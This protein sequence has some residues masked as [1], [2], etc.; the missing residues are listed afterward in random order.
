MATT[1]TWNVSTVDTYPT[2]TDDNSNTES[3]VIFNVHWRLSGDDS[4]NTASVIGTQSLDVSDIST[5]TD[6]DSVTSSDVEGW[7]T[8][9]MGAD[10]VQELKD[11][12]QAQLNELASPTVVTR[13]IS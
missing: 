7:V 6:F 2:H 13:Q 1:Y 3:D 9:E 8:A 5:F 12:V 11:N 4:T 10:K